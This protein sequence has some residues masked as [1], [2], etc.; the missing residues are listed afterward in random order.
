MEG[1]E[2]AIAAAGNK[3]R[4]AKLLGISHQSINE[5]RRIPAERIIQIEQVTDVPREKL[6]PDLY[7]PRRAKK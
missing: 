4:L 2:L 3:L 1:V 5:W 6:R 7:A